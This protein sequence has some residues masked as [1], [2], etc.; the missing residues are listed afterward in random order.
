MQAFSAG[1][2]KGEP[3][4]IGVST[5]SSVSL[6]CV[7]IF[8]YMWEECAYAQLPI[9][10][11]LPVTQQSDHLLL[12][13]IPLPMSLKDNH[14]AYKLAKFSNEHVQCIHN[15]ILRLPIATWRPRSMDISHPPDH[16]SQRNNI[17]NQA[18]AKSR[19]TYNKKRDCCSYWKK[20]KRK[21]AGKLVQGTDRHELYNVEAKVDWN[22]QIENYKEGNQEREQ[23]WWQRKVESG[24]RDTKSA[25]WYVSDTIKRSRKK[26]K[27][28]VVFLN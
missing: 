28:L 18:Y 24:V 2:V 17:S 10:L 20:E 27:G 26:R 1:R 6:V 25:T 22:D 21:K 15:L 3:R 19:D 4:D 14:C 9:N 8:F 23:G 11:Y 16:D 12:T 7:C 5:R 13:S